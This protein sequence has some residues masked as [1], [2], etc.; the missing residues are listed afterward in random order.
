MLKYNSAF[1]RY[2]TDIIRGELTYPDLPK[3]LGPLQHILYRWA[4][5]EIARHQR[6]LAKAER[7]ASASVVR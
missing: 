1:W 7:H 6:D 5:W 3:K 2:L 4:D